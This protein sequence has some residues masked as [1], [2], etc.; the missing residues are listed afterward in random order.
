MSDWQIL[1]TYTKVRDGSPE[2]PDVPIYAFTVKSVS[3][4][5]GADASV[6]PCIKFPWT[7]WTEAADGRAT[8]VFRTLSGAVEKTIDRPMPFVAKRMSADLEAAYKKFEANLEPGKS[9]FPPVDPAGGAPSTELGEDSWSAVIGTLSSSDERVARELG[10]V[11]W[12]QTQ[13]KWDQP[14]VPKL[15]DFDPP[16]LSESDPSE[17]PRVLK[18]LYKTTP[19]IG[20]AASAHT[21]T[22]SL[23]LGGEDVIW[24]R[25]EFGIAK[26]LIGET[27]SFEADAW[28]N[29]RKDLPARLA[30]CIDPLTW[31]HAVVAQHNL[32]GAKRA[33]LEEALDLFLARA[34]PGLRSSPSF[35]PLAPNRSKKP[36]DWHGTVAFELL[37]HVCRDQDL[38]AS[39][40]YEANEF[41]SK[42]VG[43]KDYRERRREIA[44][45]NVLLQHRWES[46]GV[47]ALRGLIDNLVFTQPR[48]ISSLKGAYGDLM[49]AFNSLGHD[50]F[51]SAVFAIRT[52]AEN[53]AVLLRQFVDEWDL[54][55]ASDM[56]N[57]LQALRVH[58]G[59]EAMAEHT[60][61]LEAKLKDAERPL[62]LRYLDGVAGSVWPSVAEMVNSGP[63]QNKAPAA[64]LAEALKVGFSQLFRDLPTLFGVQW[65]AGLEKQITD[66]IAAD[67]FD[68]LPLV[69]GALIRNQPVP[70]LYSLG[71]T[72]AKKGPFDPAVAAPPPL[73]FD[74]PAAI[75][76]FSDHFAGVLLVM[77]RIDPS[78]PN[79]RWSCITRG[80]LSV[81]P[82]AQ[83]KVT[84]D[85]DLQLLNKRHLTPIPVTEAIRIAT[86][87]IDFADEFIGPDRA[88]SAGGVTGKANDSSRE[89]APG[90]QLVVR[91]PE[92]LPADALPPGRIY[93]ADF[94]CQIGF[95]PVHHS[96]ALPPEFSA[97]TGAADIGAF[98][99]SPTLPSDAR[100]TT[101]RRYVRRV[102][103]G[104]V[105]FSL[106][107]S[108]ISTM[109]EIPQLP[110][111]PRGVKPL[112]RELPAA[113]KPDSDTPLLLLSRDMGSW[114]AS[115]APPSTGF[116]NWK[117]MARTLVDPDWIPA[118]DAFH[119]LRPLAPDGVLDEEKEPGT[120]P[121]DDPAV[122]AVQIIVRERFSLDRGV[123]GQG[124]PGEALS[125]EVLS[126]E[127]FSTSAPPKPPAFGTKVDLALIQAWLQR[128][129]GQIIIKRDASVSAISLKKEKDRCTLVVPPGS[130][131]EVLF[132][133][134]VEK[135][136]LKRFATPEDPKK[137]WF[138]DLVGGKYHPTHGE[139]R[140]LVESTPR[141][142]GESIADI[143]AWRKLFL[144][145]A[146]DVLRS[147]RL[148]SALDHTTIPPQVGRLEAVL[149]PQGLTDT[150][151]VANGRWAMVSRVLI[152]LQPWRWHGMPHRPEVLARIADLRTAL[153]DAEFSLLTEEFKEEE[154][155]A[156]GARE[157]DDSLARSK[158]VSI[159]APRPQCRI[160]ERNKAWLAVKDQAF[161]RD[162]AKTELALRYAQTDEEHLLFKEGGPLESY[163]R[164]YRAHITVY[165]R[166]WSPPENGRPI[167]GISDFREAE[168]SGFHV[169]SAGS[170]QFRR[171]LIPG[172]LETAL[173]LPPLKMIVPGLHGLSKS[174][175]AS[176]RRRPGFFAFVQDEH[177]S[178][179]RRLTARV[180]DVRGRFGK[181]YASSQEISL[182]EAAPDPGQSLRTFK[183][184]P[185]ALAA[186]RAPMCGSPIGLTFER[187]AGSP[188]F[189]NSAFYF[190]FGGDAY[191]LVAKLLEEATEL[192]MIDLFAKVALRW[193]L[194]SEELMVATPPGFMAGPETMPVQLRLLSGFTQVRV[195]SSPTPVEIDTLTFSLRDRKLEFHLKE[196]SAV[197]VTPYDFP[198]AGMAK[199][200]PSFEPRLLFVAC[201]AATRGLADAV[202]V[203]GFYAIDQVGDV[204]KIEGLSAE[205]VD[206]GQGTDEKEQAFRQSAPM[207]GYFIL[208]HVTRGT[209]LWPPKTTS[210]F[211]T[212]FFPIEGVDA[213]D[214]KPHAAPDAQGMM[215]RCSS[216]IFTQPLSP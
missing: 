73:T 64:L 157:L 43:D 103:V 71:E 116:E 77:R 26:G 53:Q 129:L 3:L 107:Q 199:I 144:P 126:I 189:P 177:V 168:M 39:V 133:P 132:K 104:A 24:N 79:A 99:T 91:P 163:P 98:T 206:P 19:S 176:G 173:P 83:N 138:G 205:S 209:S 156:F 84:L 82:T 96:G 72:F 112:A 69:S 105:R 67:T 65:Q 212:L 182:L 109:E 123:I 36:E 131:C 50:D 175:C 42:K 32:D 124:L 1:A 208:C 191:D 193:E 148:R 139:T 7:E 150:P 195:N 114:E 4:A 210:E 145:C 16:V 108:G 89:L 113:G 44:L 181:D 165:S 90:L 197:K 170:T 121:V 49:A 135:E 172:R 142:R 102:K 30:E 92:G 203:G 40:L 66:A 75:K 46:K 21:I 164:Y 141:T 159:L 13:E 88:P 179:F 37:S 161:D 87:Q 187:E 10:L 5:G 56:T 100:V 134:C 213:D 122:E 81:K 97:S 95:I 111:L 55:I 207:F 106:P 180:V 137:P 20:D 45:R 59:R 115:L 117:I 110:T 155:L 27:A 147:L 185:A 33:V 136:M 186:L 28:S 58:T 201:H 130:V 31:W 8:R 162:A 216:T 149:V 94:E 57:R 146:S 125:S 11:A 158:T 93:D 60:P 214:P 140:L 118:V 23:Q 2:Y 85:A 166:Y 171:W 169:H 151:S 188:L 183:D 178:P 74:S 192:G 119:F 204:R 78:N 12:I 48:P 61:A 22:L 215:V 128:T 101:I 196:Q 34:D 86:S 143:D 80:E 200:A 41:F 54:L 35:L 194:S 120:N 211:L 127:A 153:P 29:W 47:E 51:Y 25:P 160:D 38:L 17:D 63:A 9:L 18:Y 198:E 62:A 190:E 14:L 52:A 70:P 154:I 6:P 15:K 202:R 174:T 76:N 184:D 167:G 152:R 68:Y